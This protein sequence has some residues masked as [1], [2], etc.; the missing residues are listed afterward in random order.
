MCISANGFLYPEIDNA[1]CVDC[2]LCSKAC[3]VN[4]K[5][6]CN[7]PNRVYLCWNKQDDIRLKSSS[8]GLFTAIASW[9]I[10]QNGIVCGATYD[11]EMN[12]IHLIVD[13]EEDLKKLRGSKYVQSNVGDS[14]RHIK[15]ALKKTNGFIS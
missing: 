6:L 1:V 10:K 13:N 15:C 7:N 8:G 12:V 4:N 9:V 5:P 14:Y 2:G 11:K 3:P